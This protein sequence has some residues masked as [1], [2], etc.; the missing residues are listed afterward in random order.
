MQ[1]TRTETN[2]TIIELK[3]DKFKW[4]DWA[5]KQKDR[6]TAKAQK[7]HHTVINCLGDE[8]KSEN[9]C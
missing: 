6:T 1:L 2:K 5:E 7:L 4:K 3:E 8:E 9:V